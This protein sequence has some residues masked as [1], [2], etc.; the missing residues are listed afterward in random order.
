MRAAVC[1]IA[2]TVADFTMAQRERLIALDL[3][4]LIVTRAGRV[5]AVDALL[6][7]NEGSQVN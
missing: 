3:N 6:E 5:V 1:R 4:P 7:T 2:A